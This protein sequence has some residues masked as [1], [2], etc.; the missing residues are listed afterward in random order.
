MRPLQLLEEWKIALLPLKL[1]T[2]TDRS[3]HEALFVSTI[4][5]K[6]IR[7]IALA[8]DFF[9]P[10]LSLLEHNKATFIQAYYLGLEWLW[11]G[12]PE[13]TITATDG[14]VQQHRLLGLL[15][16]PKNRLNLRIILHQESGS[17]RI[18]ELMS[19]FCFPNW[20]PFGSI[21]DSTMT[22]S[23]RCPIRDLTPFNIYTLWFLKVFWSWAPSSGTLEHL[24]KYFT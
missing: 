17:L 8:D 15:V 3:S 7:S 2:L 16:N 4:V 13:F 11:K 24:P 21:K 6:E 5:K 12:G 23:F 22:P 14:M 10:T 9:Y 20:W 18:S 19:K 1:F